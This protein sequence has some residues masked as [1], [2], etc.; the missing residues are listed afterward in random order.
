MWSGAAE[1]DTI[2]RRMTKGESVR[3][4]MRVSSFCV[5]VTLV[6]LS[7]ATAAGDTYVIDPDGTGDFPTIQDAVNAATDGDIIEL[8]QGTF[9]GDGNRDIQVPSRP[10]TIRAEYGGNYMNCQIDCDG[11]AREEH[12]GFRFGPEVGTGD[13][14][15]EGIGIING[16]TTGNGGGIRVEGADPTIDNCA[17]VFCTADGSDT[18]GGGI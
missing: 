4:A 14:T 6:L 18:K 15:L 11:S 10:I 3:T 13:A 9:T 2:D 1:G 8:M 17:V 7:A 16:Y 5:I 12:R